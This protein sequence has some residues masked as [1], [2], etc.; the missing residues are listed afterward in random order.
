MIDY[1]HFIL[2]NFFQ[3]LSGNGSHQEFKSIVMIIL[4]DDMW[5]FMMKFAP[6]RAVSI[7]SFIF[8]SEVRIKEINKLPPVDFIHFHKPFNGMLLG[9]GS[10][11]S[12]VV[13]SHLSALFEEMKDDEKMEYV[14]LEHSKLLVLKFEEFIKI[15]PDRTAN[16]RN[17]VKNYQVFLS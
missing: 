8:C 17:M 10:T 11:N 16:F 12:E 4:K 13:V 6:I 1:I 9:S 2:A 3:D 14:Q 15:N 5:K 7:I